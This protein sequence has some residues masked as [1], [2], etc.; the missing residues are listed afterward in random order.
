MSAAFASPKFPILAKCP[1]GLEQVLASEL[2]ALGAEEIEP[3]LRAVAFRGDRRMLYA[4]NYHCR[5][6]LRILLPFSRFTIATESDLYTQVKAIRWEEY[7][8]ASDTFAI[9]STL[10]NSVY[11]HSHYASQR[12]KDAIAD[13]FRDRTGKRPSVNIEDPD[14][15]INLHMSRNEVT[16]SFDSSGTSLHR[17]G[18]HVANAEAPLSEVLAAGMVLL[19]GWDG[20]TNFIDPM[21]GSGTLLTEAAMIAMNLPAGYFRE[22]F[23]FMKWK[24]FSKE[25]WEDILNEALDN[26]QDIE[27]I[28]RG[29]D[30][31]A[32]NLEAAAAN[33]KAARLHKDVELEVMP[34]Q[35]VVPPPPPGVVITNPPYGEKIRVEDINALYKELGNAFKRN[36]SG[37]RAWVISSDQQ[38]LKL[39]GLK[40]GKKFTLFNG[41]LECRYAGY[42]LYEGSRREFLTSNPHGRVNP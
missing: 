9:D 35:K 28:I 37:Y 41:P 4:A 23:G 29:S 26:Q 42:D 11:T 22:S 24:D 19:S 15:R 2:E 38:A 17:R 36:F 18:Y 32:K 12:T 30:I 6:A 8:S 25:L 16:L 13:R 10:L 33:L 27:C 1:S 31:S 5:T 39:I 34:F 40:P 7:F 21:C 14:F 3:Q 20:Q